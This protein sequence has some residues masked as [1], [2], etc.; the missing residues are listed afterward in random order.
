MEEF[1]KKKDSDTRP[2]YPLHLGLRYMQ[3]FLE[4]LGHCV[5]L[6]F[7]KGAFFMGR[8]SLDVG[9]LLFWES[10]TTGMITW[11]YTLNLK[12]ASDCSSNS[13]S[14]TKTN[15]PFAITDEMLRFLACLRQTHESLDGRMLVPYQCVVLREDW[16]TLREL[17]A[18]AFGKQ[19]AAYRRANGGSLSW[20]WWQG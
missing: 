10:S 18:P 4:R 3:C 9:W 8:W 20:T 17:F 1:T 13:N 7:P 11:E 16:E 2:G 6:G 14:S 12:Y 5:Q 19:K 15:Q